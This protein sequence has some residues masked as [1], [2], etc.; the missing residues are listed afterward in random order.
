MLCC[1]VIEWHNHLVVYC[2]HTPDLIRMALY[3]WC[4]CQTLLY[5]RRHWW[6]PHWYNTSSVTLS[7]L[8]FCTDHTIPL[9][10]QPCIHHSISTVWTSLT[11]TV[12]WRFSHHGSKLF[13]LTWPF[14]TNS[15]A[16]STSEV[17]TC[18]LKER[19]WDA[20]LPFLGQWARRWICVHYWVC[21]A[22]TVSS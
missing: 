5:S 8:I 17:V 9:L 1:V 2:W 7:H 12:L 19:G 14:T 21:D 6:L 18:K 3:L 20:R 22:W 4:L 11:R 15:T 16:A 13:C 10:F